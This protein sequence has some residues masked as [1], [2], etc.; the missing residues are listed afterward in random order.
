[1]HLTSILNG[2]RVHTGPLW[3][4]CPF[5]TIFAHIQKCTRHITAFLIIFNP[6]MDPRGKK[7]IVPTNLPVQ[8]Y[9]E[10]KPSDFRN[11][12]HK[13]D[14][15]DTQCYKTSRSNL[16]IKGITWTSSAS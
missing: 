12:S 16:I 2:L 9:L 6:Q 8:H 4:T 10:A 7:E 3:A 14:F 5:Y 1:M 11:I 15:H 13:L